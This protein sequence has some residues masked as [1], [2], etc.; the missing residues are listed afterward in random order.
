M[1]IS[2]G[3][4]EQMQEEHDHGSNLHDLLKEDEGMKL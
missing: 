3:A 4:A 2:S 1:P